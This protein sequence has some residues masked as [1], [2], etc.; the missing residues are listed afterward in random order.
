MF[1]LMPFWIFMIA[2]GFMMLRGGLKDDSVAMG[3][4]LIAA[5]LSAVGCRLTL[6]SLWREHNRQRDQEYIKSVVTQSMGD[7]HY[8]STPAHVWNPDE[9]SDEAVD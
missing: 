1:S 9:H 2:A 7:R 6:D 3:L 5:V 8:A 4:G